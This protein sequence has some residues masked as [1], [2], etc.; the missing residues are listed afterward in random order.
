VI[1][2][3][4]DGALDAEETEDF[5][6]RMEEALGRPVLWVHPDGKARR[7][8]PLPLRTRLR[9]RIRRRFDRVCGWLCGA[10]CEW[11]ART[12]RKTMGMM[13]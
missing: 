10:H 12:I 3:P 11:I 9:L 8:L 5:R 6:Q 7:R 1:L 2:P 13:K 4:G